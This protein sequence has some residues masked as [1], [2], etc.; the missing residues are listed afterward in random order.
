MEHCKSS[1]RL[2]Y[3]DG[4]R[5]SVS[6][7]RRKRFQGSYLAFGPGISEVVGEPCC[8]LCSIDVEPSLLAEADSSPCN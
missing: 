6:E 8:V 2:E 1:R 7:S 3:L 5:L 4:Y